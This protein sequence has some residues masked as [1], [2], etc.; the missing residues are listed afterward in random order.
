MNRV[1]LPG[2]SAERSIYS[3]GG[4]FHSAASGIYD[5]GGAEVKPTSHATGDVIEPQAPA[6]GK[7]CFTCRSSC[8]IRWR[9]N[10]IQLNRCL[11]RCPCD[12]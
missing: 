8:V 4:T 10:E 11:D 6:A 5:F 7:A 3:D 2:F 12:F 9:K 1:N